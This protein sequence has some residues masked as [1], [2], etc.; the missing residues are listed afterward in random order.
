MRVCF[1][2]RIYMS[3][4]SRRRRRA[5]RR[6]ASTDPRPVRAPEGAPVDATN[7]AVIAAAAPPTPILDASVQEPPHAFTGEVYDKHA[8][9]LQEGVE[10]DTADRAWSQKKLE[11]TWKN[12][13]ERYRSVA[14]EA[15]MPAELVAALHFRESSGNFSTYLHQGDPLGKPAKHVPKDIPVFH[16]WE[17]GAAHALGMK[18]NVQDD[19]GLTAE[20]TDEAAMATYAEYY[21]GLGYHN[22]DA[23]SPYVYA[24]TDGYD[25][26]KYVADGKYSSKAVDKQLGVVSMIRSIQELEAAEAAE[27]QSAGKR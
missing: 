27:A 16:E 23:A 9:T 12:N 10:V 3:V 18:K 15:D 5:Q 25:K 19:L 26:G 21:N 20:T 7:E 13:E 6:A 17:D 8:R 24:G 4:F 14:D 11:K 1:S 2:V 22:R